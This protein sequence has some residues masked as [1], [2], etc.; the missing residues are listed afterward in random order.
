MTALHIKGPALTNAAITFH[1]NM[2]RNATLLHGFHGRCSRRAS[3]EVQNNAA[4]DRHGS[5]SVNWIVN[6]SDDAM[7]G[8]GHGILLG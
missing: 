4:T 5:A 1:N 8:D 2:S 6:S 3:S 7:I